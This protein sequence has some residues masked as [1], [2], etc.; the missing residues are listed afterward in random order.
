MLSQVLNIQQ[1]GV[2]LRPQLV[3]YQ[4]V[5]HQLGAQSWRTNKRHAGRSEGKKRT[6][7]MLSWFQ[8]HPKGHLWC[9]FRAVDLAGL[10]ILLEPFETSATSISRKCARWPGCLLQNGSGPSDFVQKKNSSQELK[11]LFSEKRNKEKKRQFQKGRVP[12]QKDVKISQQG[13]L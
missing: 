12:E 2:L 4:Q 13:A 7:N 6:I 5:S 1:H 9:W 10:V 11:F 3:S 8:L